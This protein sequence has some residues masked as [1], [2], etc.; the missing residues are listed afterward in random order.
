M[1]IVRFCLYQKS[2]QMDRNLQVN[3]NKNY[4]NLEPSIPRAWKLC[5]LSIHSDIQFNQKKTSWE[6]KMYKWTIFSRPMKITNPRRAFWI[7]L[8]L[9]MNFQ[10]KFWICCLASRQEMIVLMSWNQNSIKEQLRLRTSWNMWERM[11][12]E[13]SKKKCF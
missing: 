3:R 10:S 2:L 6:S 4:K 5:R 1:L 7:L 8:N 9:K 13:N 12:K 11:S